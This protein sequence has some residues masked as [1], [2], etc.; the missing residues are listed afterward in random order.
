MVFLFATAGLFLSAA[1]VTSLGFAIQGPA[2]AI[3]GWSLAVWH[4]RC[5]ASLHALPSTQT[6]SVGPR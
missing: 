1:S 2:L 3:V 6:P 5:V 4:T